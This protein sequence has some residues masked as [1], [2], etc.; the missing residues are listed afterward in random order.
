[1]STDIPA[2]PPSPP[3]PPPPD[4]E[5]GSS[6]LSRFIYSVFFWCMTGVVIIYGI[7]LYHDVPLHPSFIPVVGAVFSG[8]V[9]FALVM[10]FKIISGPINI[11]S[12]NYKLEGASGPIV[13]WCVCFLTISYG[14]YLLGLVDVAKVDTKQGYVSC[15]VTDAI[16]KIC[17]S[18]QIKS[19]LP[20]KP[21]GAAPGPGLPPAPK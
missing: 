6:V 11:Q 8:L 20:D 10:S 16:S 21:D 3:P 12:G 15:S 5:I 9:S 18:Q 4:P 2:P 1:M 17:P 7:R 19:R 14:L 13:L